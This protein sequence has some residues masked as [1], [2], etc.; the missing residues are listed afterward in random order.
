MSFI[1]TYFKDYKKQGGIREL[2][3]LALPM[4]ASTACD[5]AMTF[6]D[7]L[8]L[9]RVGSEYMNAAMGGFVTYQMLIFFFVG[10][11]GYVTALVAQYYGADRKTK[12]PVATF[13]A[14]LLVLCALPVIFLLKPL[15]VHIIVGMKVS[16]VQAVLQTEYLRWLVAGAAFAM[17]RQVMA[18]FFTGV[19]RSTV[20]LK[21]T[22]LALTIN[23][24]LDYIL[25][26]GKLGFF[27]MGIKGAAVATVLGNVAAMCWFLKVY[28]SKPFRMAFHTH[29]SFRYDADSMRRLLRYGYP[30]GL[31]MFL[32]FVAFFMMTNMFQAQGVA[33][34]T[35]TSIMFN[36]DMLS[37]IPL[38]GIEI[39]TTSLVG[40]FMGAEKPHLAHRT[41]VS[42]AKT[43]VFYSLVVLMLFLGIP[44]ALVRLFHPGGPSVDFERAVPLAQSMLRIAS[45]YVLA[46]AVMIALIATLRGAGDTLYTMM[47]SVGA[48]WAFLPIQYLA[49]YVC[50][51]SVPLTWFLLVVM[52]LSFCWIM[53][54]RFRS[55]KWKALRII[56]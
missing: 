21:A 48:N 26:F 22:L 55:G 3:I 42:A 29:K 24:V 16:P 8:F 23:I 56:Q 36:Y 33:E 14:V 46:Q 37:F 32:G 45:L 40:R 31:E 25:I 2:L 12:A 39:A 6:T 34:A 52:Y 17:L 7:R 5:G 43:G 49:L 30:A 38:L 1:Q 51:A 19:G 4:M 28:F 15:A 13:Q 10:L 50:G 11:T 53:F 54:Q 41:A 35:A 44:E 9:S 47:V 27:P 20:V 18:C